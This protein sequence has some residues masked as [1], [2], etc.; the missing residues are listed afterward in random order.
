MDASSKIEI[1]R[2]ARAWFR[3]SVAEKHAYNTRKF[4]NPRNLIINPFLVNYLANFLTG[5]NSPES[6]AKA[7]LYPKVL[8]TSITTSFGTNIQ[9]FASEVLSGYGSMIPGIDIEFIDQIDQGRKYCQLKAGPNTINKDDVE[10]IHGHFDSARKLARTNNL[11]IGYG[12]LIVGVFYGEENQLSSHYKRLESQYS[13]PVIVG[14]DF[15]QRLTGDP[16]FYFDLINQFASVATEIDGTELMK[17]TIEQLAKT[18]LIQQL[19]QQNSP[20]T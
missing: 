18:D 12:D 10:S 2:K 15:W 4:S 1:L 20:K 17:D 13:H 9:K 6:I 5:D 3:H 8:G 19:S 14:Q 16:D 7:L 11:T